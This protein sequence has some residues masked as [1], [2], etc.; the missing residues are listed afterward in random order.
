MKAI[1]ASAFYPPLGYTLHL[2]VDIIIKKKTL[3]TET[4]EIAPCLFSEDYLNWYLF[5]SK[6][7]PKYI[8]QTLFFPVSSPL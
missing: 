4:S 8:E 3:C 7:D 2:V 1:A 5:P 6:S